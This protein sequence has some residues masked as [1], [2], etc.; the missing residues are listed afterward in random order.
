[1]STTDILFTD[2]KAAPVINMNAVSDKTKAEVKVKLAASRVKQD[3]YFLSLNPD[4]DKDKAALTKSVEL[5]EQ[6][7]EALSQFK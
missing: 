1:M 6:A 2:A 5:H 7:V 3:Q 4:G